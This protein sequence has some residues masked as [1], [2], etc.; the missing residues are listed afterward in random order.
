MRHFGVEL[1][2]SQHVERHERKGK[3]IMAPPATSTIATN[4][5]PLSK[6]MFAIY[7]VLVSLALSSCSANYKLVVPSTDFT[8]DWNSTINYPEPSIH[9]SHGVYRLNDGA[10]VVYGHTDKEI[11]MWVLQSQ[12]GS[13]NLGCAT[14]LR[15]VTGMSRSH[16]GEIIKNTTGEKSAIIDDNNITFY[17]NRTHGALSCAVHYYISKENT[18]S[19]G[20]GKYADTTNKINNSVREAQEAIMVYQAVKSKAGA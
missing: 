1:I 8:Y 18:K 4:T 16:A 14:L 10:L 13:A 9:G 6:G 12:S 15:Q 20:Q 3:I 5:N 2:V 17:I 19:L 11:P 7:F